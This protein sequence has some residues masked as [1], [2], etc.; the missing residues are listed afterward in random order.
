MQDL[1]AFL[2]TAREALVHVAPGRGLINA[3][4]LHL[5]EQFTA[6]IA[7]RNKRHFPLTIV[8]W[9]YWPTVTGRAYCAKR[10]TQKIGQ[11]YAWN[12]RRILES[13]KQPMAGPLIG[14]EFQEVFI[15]QKHLSS[16]DV[17]FGVPHQGIGQCAFA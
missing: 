7:H 8:R 17:V 9:L 3:Q 11:G 5:L 2:L 4:V 6:K 1:D 13:Q 10:P 15:P 12:S 16:F 14:A